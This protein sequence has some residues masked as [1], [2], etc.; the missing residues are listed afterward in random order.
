MD[1]VTAGRRRGGSFLSGVAPKGADLG[2]RSKAQQKVSRVLLTAALRRSALVLLPQQ[3]RLPALRGLVGRDLPGGG[4]LSGTEFFESIKIG[5]LPKAIRAP[6]IKEGGSGMRNACKLTAS[7]ETAL[8][9]GIS[10]FG[11]QLDV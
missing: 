9:L 8:F 4:P 7:Q 2:P 6:K 1:R 5:C 11:V 10:G 3:Q